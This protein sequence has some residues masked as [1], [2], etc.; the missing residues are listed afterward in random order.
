MRGNLSKRVDFENVIA[1]CIGKVE[2]EGWCFMTEVF[3]GKFPRRRSQFSV[4]TFF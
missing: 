4:E 3:L 1:R 2:K